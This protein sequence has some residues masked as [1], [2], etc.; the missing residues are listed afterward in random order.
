MKPTHFSKQLLVFPL[1]AFYCQI[2][3]AQN[4]EQ[5]T[6][7]QAQ[8]I[9]VGKN[10]VVWATGTNN[11]IYRLNGSSWETIPGTASRVAVD[12]DGAAWVVN[13]AGSIFKYNLANK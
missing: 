3:S 7:L 9:A 12:P 1:L 13:S 2:L 11:A 10:G 5:L 6:G 8:D 4:W